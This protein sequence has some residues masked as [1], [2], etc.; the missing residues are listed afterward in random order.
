DPCE[1]ELG[2]V[3]E[4]AGGEDRDVP[5]PLGDHARDVAPHGVA[6]LRG[7]RRRDEAV[8]P[9]RHQRRDGPATGKAWPRATAA[10]GGCGR[11][12]SAA[13][14]AAA[15]VCPISRTTVISASTICRPCGPTL[16]P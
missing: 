4:P 10:V 7:R 1:R 3:A 12:M 2:E 5:R 16:S 6:A 14:A 15:S 11:A 9:D 13:G 8:D